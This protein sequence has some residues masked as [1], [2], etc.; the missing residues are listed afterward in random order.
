M[1]LSAELGQ[2]AAAIRLLVLDV[3]GVL[4]DGRLVYGPHGEQLK[5]FHVRDGLGLRLVRD[6][7]VEVAVITA[8]GSEALEARMRDLRI[9]RVL[10]RQD[11]KRRALDK[12]LAETGITASEC[13]YVGDDV[14]DLPVLRCVGLAVAVADA[15]PLVRAEAHVTTEARGGEGAVREVCDALLECKTGLAHAVE[16]FLARGLVQRDKEQP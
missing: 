16:H 14:I 8:R 1:Q 5:V 7:G 10:S 15:H 3:D 12:L 6:A 9:T 13:A 11:D 2:R 4:T